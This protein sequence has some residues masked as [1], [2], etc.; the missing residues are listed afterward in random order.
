MLTFQKQIVV[1]IPAREHHI[2]S[3]WATNVVE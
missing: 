3:S 2:L 1:L